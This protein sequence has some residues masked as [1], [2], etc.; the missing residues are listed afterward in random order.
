MA[1]GPRRIA[2]RSS[3]A[4]KIG[5]GTVEETHELSQLLQF[6]SQT[7]EVVNERK[8]Q[9]LSNTLIVFQEVETLALTCHWRNIIV[10]VLPQRTSS[11]SNFESKIDESCAVFCHIRPPNKGSLCSKEMVTFVDTWDLGNPYI[12]RDP[13]RVFVGNS[14]STR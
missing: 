11:Y 1:A 2:F 4:K 9:L 8:P 5:H 14:A 3:R 7:L 10:I 13:G 12:F 6:P